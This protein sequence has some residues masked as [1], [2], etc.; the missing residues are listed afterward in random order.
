MLGTN[1]IQQFQETSFEIGRP[2]VFGFLGG[3]FVS[4]FISPIL[5]LGIGIMSSL[6]ITKFVMHDT[7][8]VFV[9]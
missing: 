1:W 9:N 2:Y 4:T 8:K 5:T 3:I 6:F 7:F